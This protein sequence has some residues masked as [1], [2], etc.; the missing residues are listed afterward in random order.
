MDRRFE[1]RLGQMLAQAEVPT[2]LVDGFLSRLEAFVR[3]FAASLASG[4]QRRHTL[5]YLTGL[6]SK[7]EHKTSEGIAY[8]HDRERQ[9]LQKFIGL[10]PWDHAPLA[11]KLAEQVADELGGADGVIVFDPS[12]FVKK[13]TKS[14]GVARQW[15]GRVGKTENCQ[16]GVYMAYVSRTEH[17]IVNARLY[18]PEEWTKDRGAA[19]RPKSRRRSGSDAPPIVALEMLDEHGACCRTRGWRAT[20]R[21]AAPSISA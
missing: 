1:A 9:G 2:D 10:S 11:L 13:G 14:V 5:E 4:D 8:L 15:C 18:L 20:T 12:G 7:L 6:L 19:R 3:P 21:W 17:A 16:V